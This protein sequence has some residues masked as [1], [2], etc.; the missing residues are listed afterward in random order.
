MQSH[1]SIHYTFRNTHI[2]NYVSSNEETPLP[3]NTPWNTA[4]VTKDNRSKKLHNIQGL[5]INPN[6]SHPATVQAC[7][8]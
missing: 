1:Q 3:S 5:N 7:V 8:L 6:A 4:Y 2:C